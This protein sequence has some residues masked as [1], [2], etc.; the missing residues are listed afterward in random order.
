MSTQKRTKTDSFAA[1]FEQN[2]KATTSPTDIRKYMVF[3]VVNQ[4]NPIGSMKTFT[5]PNFN[6]FMKRR[7]MI[8]EKIRYN[9]VTIMNKNS[10]IYGTYPHKTTFYKFGLSTDDS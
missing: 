2:F 7:L 9:R 1:H 5:K 8:L 6:L 4:L 10:E 3:K